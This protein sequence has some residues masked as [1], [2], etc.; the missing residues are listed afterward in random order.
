MFN[1]RSDADPS[2]NGRDIIQLRGS[3]KIP[4]FKKKYEEM[5]L[6][7]FMLSRSVEEREDKFK[8]EVAEGFS[9]VIVGDYTVTLTSCHPT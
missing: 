4:L 7:P 3:V 8:E 2:K 1:K 5:K 6:K 9:E